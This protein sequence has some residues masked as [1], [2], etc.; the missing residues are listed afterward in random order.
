MYESGYEFS[1]LYPFSTA[2]Y[3][4]FGYELCVEK[5]QYKLRLSFIPQYNVDG[6]CELAELSN[7]HL[8]DI[9]IIH[10]NWQKRYNMMVENEPCDYLWLTNTNPVKEQVYTYLYKDK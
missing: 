6:Y 2:Y 3:R 5:M 4:K 7:T 9:R 8:D 1:Y 10:E